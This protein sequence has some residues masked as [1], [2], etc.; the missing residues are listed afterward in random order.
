M[1][2]LLR[3]SATHTNPLASIMMLRRLAGILPA[4][5]LDL[6]TSVVYSTLQRQLGWTARWLSWAAWGSAAHLDPQV[7]PFYHHHSAPGHA[8]FVSAGLVNFELR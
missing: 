2:H 7:R 5:A 8:A 3:H 6:A 4:T 1:L